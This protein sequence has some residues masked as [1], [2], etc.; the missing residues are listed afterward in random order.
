MS[1]SRRTRGCG[2]TSSVVR[3]AMEL[4]LLN[5]KDPNY[6]VVVIVASHGEAN[7]L[8]QR[9]NDSRIYFRTARRAQDIA[10]YL[11]PVLVDHRYYTD[12]IVQMSGLAR[13]GANLLMKPMTDPFWRIQR[14][15]HAIEVDRLTG[16]ILAFAHLEVP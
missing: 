13:Q 16:L 2:R 4:V 12:L 14:D 15:S 5:C 9:T 7:R 3:H 10:G 6:R 11:C 8:R 1:S